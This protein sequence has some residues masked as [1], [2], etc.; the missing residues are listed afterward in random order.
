M[1]HRWP[2]KR[3]FLDLTSKDF[4]LQKVNSSFSFPKSSR[5]DRLVELFFKEENL[6]QQTEQVKGK[7]ARS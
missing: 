1:T 6:G 7:S 4:F 2:K 3:N 5:Q